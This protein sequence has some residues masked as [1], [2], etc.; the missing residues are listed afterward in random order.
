VLQCGFVNCA[1]P[2]DTARFVTGDGFR[3]WLLHLKIVSFSAL[4]ASVAQV[5]VFWFLT[6]RVMTLFRLFE[7]TYG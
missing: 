1:L 3:Q 4:T 2:V 7:E 6:T 5:A